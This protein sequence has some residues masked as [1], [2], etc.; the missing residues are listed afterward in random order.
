MQFLNICN[1]A[2]Q[3]ELKRQ[4]ERGLQCKL[5]ENFEPVIVKVQ[6]TDTREGT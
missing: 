6:V 5:L 2:I 1:R 3:E 4:A